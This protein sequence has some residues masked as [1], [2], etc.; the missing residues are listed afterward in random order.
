MEDNDFGCAKIVPHLDVRKKNRNALN[1][2]STMKTKER[3]MKYT[4]T[5]TRAIAAISIAIGSLVAEANAAVVIN[6]W[7]DGSDVRGQASGTLNITGLVSSA[8][9]V[10][11]PNDFRIQPDGAEVFF[12]GPGDLYDG[13]TA[14]PNFGT[15]TLNTTGSSTG[16]H[17]GFEAGRLLV[18]TGFISGGTIFSEGIFSSITLSALGA[19]V[20][21]YNYV[22]P[23]D[24]ITLVV[25]QAPIPEPSTG[26]L[27]GL[28]SIA[29]VALRRRTV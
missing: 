15:G 25:G 29:L 23:S 5:S 16:D 13:I 1:R 17:F 8:G 20:G 7:E 21:S 4:R 18:P 24:T 14:S 22:L 11:F 6:L 3:T 9:N 28:G 26:L 2:K 27:L 12:F 19:S 10:G